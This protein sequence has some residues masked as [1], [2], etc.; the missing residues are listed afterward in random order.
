MLWVGRHGP[1]GGKALAIGVGITVGRR[2]ST[3]RVTRRRRDLK[4][5]IDSVVVA[6]S[7]DLGFGWA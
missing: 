6:S 7:T 1:G 5:H 3:A 4:S 2:R